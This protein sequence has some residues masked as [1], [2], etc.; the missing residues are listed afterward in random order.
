MLEVSSP[1]FLSRRSAELEPQQAR[2]VF[3]AYPTLGAASWAGPLRMAFA[4]AAHSA[5]LRLGIPQGFGRNPTRYRGIHRNCPHALRR[6]HLVGVVHA[7][8]VDAHGRLAD[9]L[10]PKE[11]RI[12][13]DA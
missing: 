13:L 8:R 6:Q 10:A 2:R 11:F 1:A 12:R 7:L 4:A 9:K 5:I 3:A